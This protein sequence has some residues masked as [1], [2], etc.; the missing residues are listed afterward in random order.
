MRGIILS[1][2]LSLWKTEL[3]LPALKKQKVETRIEAR[4]QALKELLDC[5]PDSHPMFGEITQGLIRAPRNKAAIV[6]VHGAKVREN[7]QHWEKRLQ[8]IARVAGNADDFDCWMTTSIQ[9]TFTLPPSEEERKKAE[10]DGKHPSYKPACQIL[11]TRFLSFL[12]D[13][14][15]SNWSKLVNSNKDNSCPFDH[16]CGRG[17]CGDKKAS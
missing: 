3:M 12:K 6:S 2:L 9:V 14:T 8:K 7:A 10:E 4:F 15:D 1:Y 5:I 16:W 13:P 17:D 11:A